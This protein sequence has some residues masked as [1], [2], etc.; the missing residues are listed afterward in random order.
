MQILELHHG[1][2]VGP[3]HN[4]N[5]VTDGITGVEIKSVKHKSGE[6]A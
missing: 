6:D 5:N 1:T 4:E 3:R 2:E